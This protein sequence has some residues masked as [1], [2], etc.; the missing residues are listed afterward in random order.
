MSDT[1][2]NEI[3]AIIREAYPDASDEEIKNAIIEYIASDLPNII[4]KLSLPPRNKLK[5]RS[6]K[7]GFLIART[8]AKSKKR[9]DIYS[10]TK[11][12]ETLE[13][14][15]D[16]KQNEGYYETAKT[17]TGHIHEIESTHSKMKSILMLVDADLSSGLDD[18][19][20]DT[21]TIRNLED[22]IGKDDGDTK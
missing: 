6:R 11:L 17:I 12:I 13:N 16:T 5:L 15:R 9:S 20:A 8:R 4:S 19:E 2:K 10:T 18:Y 7:E 22:I 21:D 1:D 14:A 3:I